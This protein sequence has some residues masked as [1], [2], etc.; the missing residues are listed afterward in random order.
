ENELEPVLG[1]ITAS[2]LLNRDNCIV[3]LDL[4]IL[5]EQVRES[6]S[7]KSRLRT[8]SMSAVRA[9]QVTHWI[10]TRNMAIRNR[11]LALVPSNSRTNAL[12]VALIMWTLLAMNLTG[13]T[14]TVKVMAPMLRSI[15]VGTPSDWA[16]NRDLRMWVLIVGYGCSAEG[17]TEAAW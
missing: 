3:P 6:Y 5:I 11:M 4:R 9:M 8:A 13:R 17:G 12:R 1:D 7:I 16:C 15:L 14:K 2:L 10:T